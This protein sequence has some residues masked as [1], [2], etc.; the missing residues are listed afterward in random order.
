MPFCEGSAVRDRRPVEP[1]TL[2]RIIGRDFDRR[3]TSA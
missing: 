3:S 2:N 1:F